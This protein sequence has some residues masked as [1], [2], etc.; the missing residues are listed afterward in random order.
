M[1]NTDNDYEARVVIRYGYDLAKIL[2]EF[3]HDGKP[4]CVKTLLEA[5]ADVKDTDNW[6]RTALHSACNSGNVKC[7]QLLLEAGSDPMATTIES[8]TPLHVAIDAGNVEVVVQL[9]TVGGVDASKE[10]SP[11]T[12]IGPRW[13]HKVRSYLEM[14][15]LLSPR[16]AVAILWSGVDRTIAEDEER[17]TLATRYLTNTGLGWVLRRKVE[18]FLDLASM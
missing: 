5:G 12:V 17:K 11:I 8:R 6:G 14:A 1:W 7:V 15:T 3:A 10:F 2:R 4:A 13:V 16:C 9:M 18:S